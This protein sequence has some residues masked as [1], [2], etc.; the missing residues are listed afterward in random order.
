MLLDPVWE[1]VADPVERVFALL[2]KY[3]SL[4]VSTD[5]QY[6]CPIGSLA[7][8]LHEPDPI[9]RE[10][11]VENFD[12]WTEAV[13]ACFAEG[14]ERFPAGTDF[15]ALGEFALTVMEG[16]VMQ[17][18]THRS[19]DYFDRAVAQLRDYVE[20]LTERETV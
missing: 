16:G 12:A 5:C 19:V 7:L 8:E 2:A 11:I 9:V 13:A 4:I 10:R 1:G 3:G 6:G 14:A 20:A 15:R 17:A 18:R